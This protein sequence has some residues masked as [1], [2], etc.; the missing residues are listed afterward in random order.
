[1]Q[2]ET[3]DVLILL[4][5]P[6][7]GKSEIIQYL[8]Q[9]PAR[10]RM[11]RFHTGVIDEIDD[12]PMLWTWF[13]EDDLLSRMGKPRLYTSPSGYFRQTYLWDLL[14][15]RISLEYQKHR[16]DYPSDGGVTTLVEFSRGKQ[17]GGFRRAFEHLSPELAQK[18]AI[19]YIDVSW[20]ESLRK[21]RARFNPARP[22]SILQHGLT[23][24]RLEHLYKGSDWKELSGGAGQGTLPI[25]GVSVPFVVFENK[26][27]LT[28][29]GGEPLGLRL[30][31]SL[32]RLWDLYVI[33]QG[34]SSQPVS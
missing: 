18:A 1:M 34:E 19:L 8:K 11:Q 20:S 15:E 14:V 10:K 16:R 25:Q 32:N 33:R 5:R 4:A 12:F 7:A 9:T 3:F 27:D 13:E 24:D 22:D 29:R 2:K 31:E 28:T 21:N 30:E 17:H 23:D 6:A 26:D